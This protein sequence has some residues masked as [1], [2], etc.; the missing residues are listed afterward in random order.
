[1]TILLNQ[2]EQLSGRLRDVRDEI[3]QLR[4]DINRLKSEQ[5]KP[6]I[7]ANV[8]LVYLLICFLGIIQL[9]WRFPLLIEMILIYLLLQRKVA[10]FS[11]IEQANCLQI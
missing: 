10:D 4:D 2:V 8:T 1:V 11:L 9:S 7:K 3:Q 5:G 6:K